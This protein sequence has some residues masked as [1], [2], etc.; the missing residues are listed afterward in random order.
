MKLTF[1][2]IFL[3]L[4]LGIALS[5]TASLPVITNAEAK[6]EQQ[7]KVIHVY[8]ELNNA[9]VNP[10]F[11]TLQRLLSDDFQL[12]TKQDTL[13]KQE[14]IKNIQEGGLKYC[15]ITESK[16]KSK[17]YNELLV[18]A[19]I[20]GDMWD[21]KGSWNVKFDIDTKQNGTKLQITKI[22]IKPATV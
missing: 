11:E 1:K 17:G 15:A 4:F 16:I 2:Q 13:T 7:E 3:S 10:N 18:T 12:V 14:W 19:R 6:Q 5:F 20:L 9:L 22:V 8:E 21:N